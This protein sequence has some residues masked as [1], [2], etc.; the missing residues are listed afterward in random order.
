M[1]IAARAGAPVKPL[2]FHPVLRAVV[3][4]GSTP[5][6]LRHDAGAP[7]A[8]VAASE[9]LWWP[10]DKI[11]GRYLAPFLAEHAQV[12]AA[13]VR[14]PKRHALFENG[15]EQEDRSTAAPPAA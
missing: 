3:L 6:Y 5:L 15:L 12:T 1:A 10:P 13:E 2:P 9:P 4:T 14:E 11:A 8:S 7:G